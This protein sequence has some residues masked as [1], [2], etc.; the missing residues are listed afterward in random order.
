MILLAT[1]EEDIT[2]DFIVLELQ[3]R[4]LPFF[5]LNSER[6]SEGFSSFSPTED[7]KSWLIHWQDRELDLSKVKAG[8][9]RRPGIPT[10]SERISDDAAKQYAASEWRSLLA[11][12]L[13][14][15]EPL[16]LNS[17][18]KIQTAENKPLQLCLAKQIGLP[19][20]RSIV[21]N[22][23]NDIIAFMKTSPV[24]IKPLREALVTISG[25]EKVLFTTLLNAN[26]LSAADVESIKACPVIMQDHVSKALDIRVTVVGNR[27]L[28]AEIH[29]QDRE[30]TKTDWRNTS[31]LD[32][33]HRAHTLPPEVSEK[34]IGLTQ[35]LGLR[36]GAIDLILDKNGVY[37]FLEINPNGQWAWI[38]NRTN[39][40]ISSAIV[41]ELE[42]ISTCSKN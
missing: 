19:V 28:A 41:D 36:F 42:E 24:I 34:C 2:T 40:K 11:S 38:E 33:L 39:L 4:G 17:P 15:I 25:E 20:P 7:G 6:L 18:L 16:W 1:N 22:C 23:Y 3:R 14:A 26:D 27:V 10:A 5:R 29:S 9:Y 12:L 35:K 31:R 21:T 8:Y 37:W 30:E 32:L 13:N